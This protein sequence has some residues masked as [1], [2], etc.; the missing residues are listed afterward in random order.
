MKKK[1]KFKM[2]LSKLYLTS[3]GAFLLGFILIFISPMFTGG[4][5]SY[6]EAKLNEYQTLNNNL[7]IAIVNKEYNPEKEFMRID[8]SIEDTS[9]ATSLSNI[10]YELSSQ[11][12]KD[13]KPLEVDITR[14]NDNYFVAIIKGIPEGYSVLSITIDPKY[15][16]PELQVTDDLKDRSIKMYINE[17][18]KIINNNLKIGTI[19]EYQDEYISFEQKLLKDEIKENKKEIETN[20]LAI[21]E[22]NKLINDLKNDMKYQTE[23]EKFETS[24]EINSYKTTIQ[25]HEKDI[26]ELNQTIDNL[27]KKIDLLNQKRES[28]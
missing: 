18:E 26:E 3:F 10:K 16:H 7:R 23:D 1:S 6:A 5:Y 19:K 17:S 13:R 4:T 20:K 27:N 24:N 9:T 28:I 11:Y 8:F 25:Q 15:I 12:I 14:I 21:K 2:N 22:I